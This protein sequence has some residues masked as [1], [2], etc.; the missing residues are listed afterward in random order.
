MFA[1]HLEA[2]LS[3]LRHGTDEYVIH[4]LRR[5]AAHRELALNCRQVAPSVSLES[6]R[7]GL[8]AYADRLEAD[9]AGLERKAARLLRAAQAPAL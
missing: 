3:L 5:A 9:A 4:L 2:G 6:R 7:L 1:E 8:L